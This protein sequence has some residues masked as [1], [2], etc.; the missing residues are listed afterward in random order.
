[1]K[2]K[3]LLIIA[4][5]CIGC[6]TKITTVLSN[7]MTAVKSEKESTPDYQK[8]DKYIENKD[9]ILL[10]EAAHGEGITFE[11][12]TKW[13]TYWI[14]EKGFNT[15]ALEG[16]DFLQLE[17]I[18]GRKSLKENLVPDFEKNWYSF[19]NP[20]N[21]AKELIPFEHFMKSNKPQLVGIEPYQKLTAI[22]NIEFIK[23]QLK[24]GKEAKASPKEW[25]KLA[26]IFDSIDNEKPI[27]EEEFDFFVFQL[28]K[29]VASNET[30]YVE[31]NFF[32]Q[33]LENLITYVSLEYNP[34]PFRNEEEKQAYRINVRDRQM[35]RNLIYFKERNP[36]AKIIVWLANFHGA[37]KIKEVSFAGG[38]PD[39]YSK[40]TVFG[41]HIKNKYA[42]KVY[43]IAITS[44]RGFSKMPF[45]LTGSEETK[46][47]APV[48]SLEF[49]LDKNNTYMGFIDFSEINKKNPK[50]KEELF[51][52]IMLGHTNQEGKWLTIFDGLLFIKENQKATPKD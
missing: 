47:T 19:W 30:I 52:S 6:H 2:K 43:S 35:A 31:D 17:Y 25:E 44:S 34:K 28:Q 24:N 13:V 7:K 27:T 41:E 51:Y 42:N 36:E 48:G 29:T 45:N 50:L 11:E 21:R 32:R 33:M 14:E 3:G 18:N 1:M 8:L 5:L 40:F 39:T 9:I 10:G 38:N 26:L 20:W 16:M 22:L 12:K 37:T 49:E 46:I 15:I 4:F 23:N